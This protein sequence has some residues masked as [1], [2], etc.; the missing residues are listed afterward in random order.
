MVNI[1]QVTIKLLREKPYLHESLEKDLVN[2]MALAELIHPEVKKELGEVKVSAISMAIRRYIEKTKNSAK[3]IKLSKETS[4]LVKSGLFEISLKKS[5]S[6]NKKL[7]RLYRHVDFEVG[8]TLNIIYGNYEVLVIS[9]EKYESKFKESL[10]GEK[11]KAMNR[12]MASISLKIP[13]EMINT[14]GF[15][16]AVTKT[17]AMNNIS[18]MDLVNTETEATFILNDKDIGK[19]YDVLKKDITI[20]YYI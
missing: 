17:L 6:L 8:D 7:I 3:K 12:N 15:Y 9:N 10:K 16:Y 19:A 5:Q 20:E 4:I 1:S 18:I 14:P 11:I 2:I 13:K